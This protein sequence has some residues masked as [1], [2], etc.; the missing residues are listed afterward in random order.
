MDI[1]ESTPRD[2]FYD[3]LRNAS[4]TLVGNELDKLLI[5]HIAISEL[6][7]RN[8]I[9]QTEINSLIAT[10]PDLIETGLNDLYI[11]I[12]GDILSQNE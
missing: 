7:E 3:I 8:N 9:S 4:P 2:K 6:L 5:Q 10:Q 12:M 11:G 1:F